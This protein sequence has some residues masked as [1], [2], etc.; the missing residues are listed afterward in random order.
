MSPKKPYLIERR[1]N[2]LLLH[3]EPLQLTPGVDFINILILFGSHVLHV[4]V[5]PPPAGQDR[6][7]VLL[8]VQVVIVVQQPVVLYGK[9]V[10]YVLNIRGFMGFLNY[11]G[12]LL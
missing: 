4:R 12:S 11:L 8:D 6:V 9:I 10:V 7:G 5:D 3:A 1:L 2:V